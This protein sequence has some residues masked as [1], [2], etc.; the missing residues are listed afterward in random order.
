M[1]K[2]RGFDSRKVI[3]ELARERV[4][5]VKSGR[6]I[7]PKRDRA[8]PKHRKGPAAEDSD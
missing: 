2:K 6:V 5:P 3:R 7:L 4:G 8:K 1:A